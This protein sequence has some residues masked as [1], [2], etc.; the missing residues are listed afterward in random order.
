MKDYLLY[1]VDLWHS[2]GMAYF[3]YNMVIKEYVKGRQRFCL[4]TKVTPVTK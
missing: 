4:F 2:N 3:Y 1:Y